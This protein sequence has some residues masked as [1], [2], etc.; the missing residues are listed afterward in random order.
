MKQRAI[1]FGFTCD[2]QI[3]VIEVDHIVQTY[4]YSIMAQN[5]NVM[6]DC[7]ISVL[8]R[9]RLH[10]EIVPGIGTETVAWMPQYPCGKNMM[11]SSNGIIFRVIGPL[12]G[13]FTGK[14]V[15]SPH[16]GQWRGALV[17]S[18]ICDWINGW[19]KNCEAGDIRRH[20]TYY[21]VIVII[22]DI[23]KIHHS[24]A[25]TKHIKTNTSKRESLNC[26]NKSVTSMPSPCL[27]LASLYY[28]L[29]ATFG[30]IG[31]GVISAGITALEHA[32]KGVMFAI[33]QAA[34]QKYTRLT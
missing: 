10:I 7:R 5:S 13:E 32:K 33:C 2:K 27:Y 8:A 17:F 15:I 14:P 24:Q 34:W 4:I 20:Q 19:V 3:L 12:C 1:Q 9:P 22:K 31:Y 11:T 25:A 18:L 21:D 16:K 30:I 6:C 29:V 28:S 23:G 26:W